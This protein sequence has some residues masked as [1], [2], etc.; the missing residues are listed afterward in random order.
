MTTFPSPWKVNH[1]SLALDSGGAGAEHQ[2]VELGSGWVGP[3]GDEWRKSW[4][5]S[6]LRYRKVG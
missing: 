4:H 2:C 3:F 1:G 5:V 6:G